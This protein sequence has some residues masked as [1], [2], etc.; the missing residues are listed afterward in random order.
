MRIHEQRQ[1]LLQQSVSKR[2]QARPAAP[3]TSADAVLDLQRSPG[4]RAT[5]A[6]PQRITVS[7]EEDEE[8]NVSLPDGTIAH[9]D[10]AGNAA[11]LA[12]D[13]SAVPAPAPTPE[14]T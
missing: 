13:A 3:Q 10:G 5:S 7:R 9:D 2:R 14:L 11:P 12:T 8:P 6:P 4:N 1:D